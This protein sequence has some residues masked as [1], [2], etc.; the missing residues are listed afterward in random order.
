MLIRPNDN[1]LLFAKNGRFLKTRKIYGPTQRLSKSTYCLYVCD[2]DDMSKQ[3]AISITYENY[4][5]ESMNSEPSKHYANLNFLPKLE[6]TIKPPSLT[7]KSTT[8][9]YSYRKQ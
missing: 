3:H 7:L 1:N 2:F 9:L 6:L 5:L 8:D 4:R